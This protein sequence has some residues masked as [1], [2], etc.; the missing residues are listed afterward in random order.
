MKVALLGA[1]RIGLVHL[2]NICMSVREMEIKTVADPV[3]TDK[4]LEM[5]INAN[6]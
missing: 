4:A 3:L 1:G 2:E 6:I 5:C